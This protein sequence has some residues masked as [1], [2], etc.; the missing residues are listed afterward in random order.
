[1]IWVKF[2]VSNVPKGSVLANASVVIWTTTPWTIPGNRAV[3][4]SS[5]V[6]YGL[7][8]VTAAP[9]GNWAKVGGKYILGDQLA[10][11]GMKSAKVEAFEKR[12]DVSAAELP[13]LVARHPLATLRYAFDRPLL[14]AH[15]VPHA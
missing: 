3:S 1:M 7:Y 2:P 8:E 11:D 12:A 14:H 10:A 9:E 6:R 4:F 15:H 5:K 13:G